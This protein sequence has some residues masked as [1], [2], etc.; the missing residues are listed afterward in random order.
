MICDRCKQTRSYSGISSTLDENLKVFLDQTY[1]E[2]LCKSCV[3]LLDEK[4]KTVHDDEDDI[5][6]EN[7]RVVFTEAYHIRRG[8]C[9]KSRCRHCPYGYHLQI[10]E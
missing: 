3:E 5:Y 8:Y 1:F 10:E 9:C 7:G 6:F 2:S 4:L